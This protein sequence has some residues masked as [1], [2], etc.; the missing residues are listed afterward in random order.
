MVTATREELVEAG[1]DVLPLV[2]WRELSMEDVV[3]Y[4]LDA[5]EETIRADE[6]EHQ[7]ALFLDASGVGN[8]LAASIQEAIRAD[9]RAKV[10]ALPDEHVYDPRLGS[11]VLRAAVLALLDGSST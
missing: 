7:G 6:R 1:C 11:C 9:L 5:V 8:V 4:V 10:Q 2:V 3:E